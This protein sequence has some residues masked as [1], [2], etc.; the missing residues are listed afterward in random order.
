MLPDALKF[1]VDENLPKVAARI[2]RDAGFDAETVVTE[3]LGGAKDVTLAAVCREE[4][5][6]LVTL[7]LDFSDIR[8]Y[9]PHEYPGII[10][11]RIHN[12]S[13]PSISAIMEK[14]V[15]LLRKERLAQFGVSMSVVSGY[16]ANNRRLHV[17]YQPYR[18]VRVI[19]EVIE[20]CTMNERD[21]GIARELKSR[22]AGM[23]ELVDYRIFGSRARGDADEYSDMDVFVEVDRLDKTLKEKILDAAWDVGFNNFMVIAPL[24]FTRNEL[25]NTPLRSSPVVKVIFQEGIQV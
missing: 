2:L 11:L 10:V 16:T 5:R 4:R 8:T 7:D 12:H 14:V 6:A 18:L 24:I 1:K 15:A 25:E 13:I 22:L 21:Y 23:V 17:K 9:P 20:R 19:I 3:G